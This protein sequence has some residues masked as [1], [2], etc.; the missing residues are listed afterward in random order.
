MPQGDA[1]K[2]G[3]CQ[4]AKNGGC[5]KNHHDHNNHP[6]RPPPPPAT[7]PVPPPPPGGPKAPGGVA[8]VSQGQQVCKTCAKTKRRQ[9][10]DGLEDATAV[11]GLGDVTA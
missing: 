9:G 6:P 2:S 5:H 4:H 3:V 8:P 7:P 11:S 1:S 10:D